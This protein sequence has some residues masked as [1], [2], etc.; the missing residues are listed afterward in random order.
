MDISIIVPTL[1]EAASVPEILEPLQTLRGIGLEVI[2]VDGGSM[3]ATVDNA[4]PLADR[5]IISAPGRA[6][7]MNR[8]AQSA[9]GSILLFLHADTLLPRYFSQFIAGGLEAS[10][11]QWGRFDVRLS[12]KHISLRVI[13]WLMNLRSRMT[14]IA[15]GDQAIFVKRELFECSGGFPCIPLMEDVALCKR[16]KKFSPPLN[17]LQRVVTS[18]RRWEA[19]GIPKTVMLMLLLRL[20][21][22]LGV[23]PERLAR[24]YYPAP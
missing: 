7:Q 9:K 1:N 21:Y 16:L 8:G 23:D 24:V 13:E 4:R 12:G 6:L 11:K 14:G 22:T 3:D 17:L 5:V 15:T 2:V 10:K 18:S 20:A 19:C